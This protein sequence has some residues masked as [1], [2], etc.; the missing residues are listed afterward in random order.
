[1]CSVPILSTFLCY[2]R[3]Q[4]EYTS[5]LACLVKTFPFK[6]E[7]RDLV[8]LT[9]YSDPESDFFEHMKHIQVRNH[10]KS[11]FCLPFCTHHTTNTFPSFRLD[12][13]AGSC[14][15]EIGQA[16]DRGHCGADVPFSPELHH[17]VRHDCPV[18]RKDAQG[19]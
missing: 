16:A 9:N 18:R 11:H 3:V 12:P 19:D 2:Q 17:A 8:Q 7:F 10:E 5:V 6:K 4:H 13:P 1:M 15:E 14:P